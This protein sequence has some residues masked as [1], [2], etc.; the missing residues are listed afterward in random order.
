MRPDYEDVVRVAKHRAVW[1]RER[2][3]IYVPTPDGPRYEGWRLE[4]GREVEAPVDP[5]L[6]AALDEFL[7]AG[8]RNALVGGYALPKSPTSPP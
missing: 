6:R 5:K 2:K 7:R 4:D 1:D 8:G 3:V